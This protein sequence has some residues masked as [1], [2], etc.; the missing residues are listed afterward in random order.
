MTIWVS[1]F[2]NLGILHSVMNH[3]FWSSKVASDS[4]QHNLEPSFHSD[5]LGH[6]SGLTTP[7]AK[8]EHAVPHFQDVVN[9][10]QHNR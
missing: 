4:F 1:L 9:E 5:D 2:L 3:Q 6:V 10:N 8:V 7:C